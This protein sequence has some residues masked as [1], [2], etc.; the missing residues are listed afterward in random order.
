MILTINTTATANA[1]ADIATCDVTPIQ[2]IEATAVNYTSLFW[3]SNGSGSFSDPSLLN[4]VYTPSTADV[5]IGMVVLT[6]NATGVG[7][8]GDTTDQLILTL[9]PLPEAE[10]GVNGT[11]CQGNSFTVSGASATVVPKVGSAAIAATV[12]I[13]NLPTQT[14]AAST[15]VALTRI[16]ATG[17]LTISEQASSD[18]GATGTWNIY[19]DYIYVK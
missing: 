4:P 3:T 19:V 10:A 11:I 7:G 6:L 9:V 16:P 2:I 13:K 17:E 1:G 5:N 15:A 12:N 18:A 14:A 8:C